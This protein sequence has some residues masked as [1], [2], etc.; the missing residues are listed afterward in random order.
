MGEH[1]KPAILLVEDSL[2]LQGLTRELLESEGYEVRCAN[3][4]LEA[5][6]ALRKTKLRVDL[7]LLDL[8]MP[9]MD[10]YQFRKQ[11][12]LDVDLA[13]IPVLVMTADGN[14]HARAMELQANGFIQKSTGIDGM[15]ETIR[16]TVSPPQAGKV[17]KSQ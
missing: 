6:D 10:G 8:R 9:V 14:A 7:I 3:N 15:L 4:G 2:D 5:L 11:Q 16:R 17:E 1:Y 13:A 12:L